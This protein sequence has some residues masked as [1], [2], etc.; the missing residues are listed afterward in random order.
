MVLVYASTPQSELY[1][2]LKADG[3]VQELYIAGAAWLP[4]HMAESTRHGANIG[5]TI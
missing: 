3:S 1:D 5:L 2:Q 4:R